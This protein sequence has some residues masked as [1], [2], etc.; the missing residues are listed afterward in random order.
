[1]MKLIRAALGFWPVATSIA[2]AACGG[3]L[4][5]V[6][7]APSIEVSAPALALST[8]QGDSVIQSVTVTSSPAGV[9]WTAMSN[10]PWLA[11]RP[12]QG[13][14]PSVVTV[15]AK[16]DALAAGTYQA[17]VT[18]SPPN[19]SAPIEIP[20]T[21]TV[22]A[23]APIS[24][25]PA[26]LAFEA[27]VDGSAPATQSIALDTN[28]RTYG[29]TAVSDSPWLS[30][31]PTSGSGPAVAV[32][33]VNPR[34]LTAGR[35]TG[36]I[37]IVAPGAANSPQS[38]AVTLTVR[39]TQY[40]VT[41][42]AAPS[43]RGTVSGAG[44]YDAGSTA[45]VTATPIVG[46][47][48][49]DWTE[50]LAVTS[51]SAQYT[52]MVSG[53]RSLVANFRPLAQ[54][55]TIVTSSSPAAG[56]TTSGGGAVTQGSSVTV[57]ATPAAGYQFQ[58]W[59]ENGVVVST[60]ASYAFTAT[61]SR[62]LVAN[63]TPVQAGS[64]Q[65]SA[66]ASPASGGTVNGAGSYASGSTV[67]LIA[68]P[69]TGYTFTNWTEG[70]V[71]VSTA[72]T[73]Q[74]VVTGNRAL[75]ANFT[76]SSTGNTYQ[77]TINRLPP[78][79]GTVTGGGSYAAGALVQLAATVNP[80]YEFTSWSENGTFLGSNLTYN[81]VATQNRTIDVTFTA[82]P[83]VTVDAVALPTNG[84]TVTGG[85]TYPYNSTVTVTATPN[86]GFTFR[87][88]TRNGNVVGTSPTLVFTALPSTSGGIVA[89]FTPIA[90]SGQFTIATSSSP[91]GAGSQT[92]AGTY[93]AG[94][95]VTV[96]GVGDDRYR[97]VNW[98]ENGQVVASAFQYKFVVDRDRSLVA[99]YIGLVK[100]TRNVN[101]SQCGT[102]F[103]Q[104]FTVGSTVSLAPMANT[105]LCVFRGWTENGQ[106]VA[107]S[108]S[109]YTFTATTDR[110]FV[111]TFA[112]RPVYS[113]ITTSNPPE[114]GG[115]EPGPSGLTAVD[116]SMV[117]VTAG[118]LPGWAFVNWTENG[119]VVSTNR[120][121]AFIIHSDRR[122]VANF[123]QQATVTIKT[124]AAFAIVGNS[125][126]ID[127]LVGSAPAVA[128]VTARLGASSI[129]LTL[130]NG[131]WTGTL[132]ISSAPRDTLTLT[133][134]A[135]DVNG[136]ATSATQQF[137]HDTPPT[138]T[139]ITP[140]NNDV[141]HP[142]IQVTAT[143]ADDRACTSITVRD[144]RVF[145]PGD[146][147]GAIL[148]SG[149]TSINQTIDLSPHIGS[150]A[151]LYFIATDSRGQQTV[152]QRDIVVQA[153]QDQ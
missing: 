116:G 134:T 58:S 106:F 100:I 145:T 135:T 84:G 87:N 62:T 105:A 79:G 51:T 55:V 29:W 69:S 107:D 38:V 54:T 114:L 32:V 23:A 77:I 64:Y 119:V 41:V 93:R 124:P 103:V 8:Q 144:G 88:W 61:A 149:T 14:T 102:S 56:G 16:A 9:A 153:S 86:S 117:T 143:C 122:L 72:A 10:S 126:A 21:L 17:K 40:L 138:I 57:T 152:V 11:V 147:Y 80:G 131:H 15:V 65:I 33:G 28:G 125:L 75:V 59:S 4:T 82:R 112:L 129:P 94:D 30:V 101:L 141:A 1:M 26:T 52:F 76:Q 110:T 139:I 45:T 39:A 81:F 5:D 18:V 3:G 96:T 6:H 118:P 19:A 123:V 133:V 98:T 83:D 78:Q 111:A 142:T 68:T 74:L 36:A 60:A 146:G 70:G 89:N 120:A 128:S 7:T 71:I 2:M 104:T 130:N 151:H 109:T 140:D 113:Y 108:T 136:L 66:S 35:Y 49:V 46:N 13:T 31:A 47:E 90:P 121:Y 137:V 20:I 115:T 132:D 50:G 22:A 48:F 12:S 97:F 37:T 34:G 91:V 43:D 24:V 99:N 127:A 44:T 63:F 92:G 67:T 85:G 42:V 53:N 25:A 148:A 27:T 95:T 150:T 73:F